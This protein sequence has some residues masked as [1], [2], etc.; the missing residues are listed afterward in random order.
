MD[1]YYQYFNNQN[2]FGLKVD[3]TRMSLLLSERSYLGGYIARIFPLVLG[4]IFLN[5]NFEKKTLII[6]FIL[7]IL[8]DVLIFIT[9]ERT[10]FGLLLISTLFIIILISKY[11][12]IRIITFFIS[13]LI[14]VAITFIDPE[15]KNRNIDHTLSQVGITEDSSK[16]YYFSLDHHRYLIT[17]WNMF[18][19]NPLFG[20][21]PNTYRIFCKDKKYYYD[22]KSCSTHPHNIY[23]QLLA[24]TG[25]IGTLPII[26]LSFY[27]ILNSIRH[28]YLYNFKGII[29]LS[30]F[31]VC[32]YACFLITL[33]PLIPSQNFFNNWISV[34]YFLPIGFYLYSTYED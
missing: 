6:F 32:L 5:Y 33:W 10:A 14:I 22:E 3:G 17:S 19:S 12:K 15:I 30:D 1:G 25:I 23:I 26:I 13:L 9:G 28:I 20:K 11:K 29:L 16:T 18:L 2:I 4:F 27:L 24:E 7:L 31:Q 8:T 34:L 21:G